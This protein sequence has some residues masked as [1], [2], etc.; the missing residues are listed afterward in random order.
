MVVDV[1]VTNSY[2][3]PLRGV[4]IIA[5]TALVTNLPITSLDSKFGMLIRCIAFCNPAR[6]ILDYSL[7]FIF[8]YICNRDNGG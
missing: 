7:N 2:V 4:W 5:I 1:Y 3:L 6:L 8:L